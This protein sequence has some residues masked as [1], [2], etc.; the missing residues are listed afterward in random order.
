[1]HPIPPA[2]RSFQVIHMDHLEPFIRSCSQNQ[3]ILVIVDSFSKFVQLYP[4]R[5]TTT[6]AT[7]KALD[8]FVTQY[9][10]PIRTVTDR[11]KAFTSKD[12][13][14]YC[15]NKGIQH[16]KVSTQR[17]Q[18]NG[19]VERI[20]RVIIPRIAMNIERP[21]HRDWDKH[22]AKIEQNLNTTRSKT[23]QKTSFEILLRL[24]CSPPRQQPP[25]T[26]RRWR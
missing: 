26:R 18:G 13:E 17:P 12:F 21:D 22:M 2:S 19:Q 5:N 9:D 23:T 8:D 1:M 20:H 10:V 6:K 16:V 14:E 11:S 15:S 7:L 24:S 4:V 3:E 25:S